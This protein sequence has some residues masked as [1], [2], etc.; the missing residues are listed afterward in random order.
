MNL[1]EILAFNELCKI[2]K[3]VYP[4]LFESKFSQNMGH[5][6][7][8]N[9]QRTKQLQ[10]YH[11]RKKSYEDEGKSLMVMPQKQMT[12]TQF[13]QQPANSQQQV[14]TTGQQSQP[15]IP[16]HQ[17]PVFLRQAA[18]FLNLSLR[19]PM[20]KQEVL[21]ILQKALKKSGGS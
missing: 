11:I 3:E 1:R 4:N 19:G 2:T 7:A 5:M 13:P 12:T 21:S 17:D 20:A 15:V 6:I 18:Y 14:P 16:Q 10:N 8:R 9:K